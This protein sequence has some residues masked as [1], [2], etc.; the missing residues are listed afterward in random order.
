MLEKNR[1]KKERNSSTR[2]EFEILE[3]GAPKLWL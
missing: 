3:F 2:T 1:E